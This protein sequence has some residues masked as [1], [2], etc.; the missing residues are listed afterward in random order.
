M[1]LRTPLRSALPWAGLVVLVVGVTTL[2]RRDP[3]VRNFEVLPRDMADSAAAETGALSSVFPDGLVMRL[4]PAGTVPVDG[5]ID[6]FLP[7]P[8]EARRAGDVLRAPE[9]DAPALLAR[10]EAAYRAYCACCH[11]VGGAGDGP[12]AKRGFP[13]PP[14]FS[15]PEAKALRDGEVWHLVVF[16]RKDM[17]AHGALVPREVRWALVRYVRSLMERVP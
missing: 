17:P 13:P 1:S 16:G 7:G 4:P 2:L 15:R 5:E 6:V 8:E 14:P 11:G 3:A 10:G 12:V 9:P